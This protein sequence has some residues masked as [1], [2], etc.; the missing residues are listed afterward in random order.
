MEM[1][2]LSLLLISPCWKKCP[3]CRHYARCFDY[4]I[5]PKIM[6]AQCRAA[7]DIDYYFEKGIKQQSLIDIQVWTLNFSWSDKNVRTKNWHG[8]PTPPPPSIPLR[9]SFSLVTSSNCQVKIARFYDF[10]FTL[11]WIEVKQKVNLYT[12]FYSRSMFHF[13]NTAIWTYEF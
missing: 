10:L 1:L 7:I 8:P 11:S 12:C 5:V 9:I 6:L 3:L 13:E 2:I 4:S